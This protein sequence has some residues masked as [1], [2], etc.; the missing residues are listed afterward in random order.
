MR[1]AWPTDSAR[2]ASDKGPDAMMFRKAAGIVAHM[3]LMAVILVLPACDQIGNPL[4]AIGARIPPP[5]EFQV[6]ARK[7][8]MM[9]AGQALPEPRPGA[10]SPLD[11]DP[12]GD[13][14][15]AL[16]GT[17]GS[18]LL[19]S[20]VPSAGELILLSSANAAVAAGDIRARLEADRV[21]EA[22]NKPFEP[23][24]VRE[25]LGIGDA[26]NL[27]EATLVDPIAEYLRL[28]REGQLTPADPAAVAATG[29]AA[30]VE[31]VLPPYPIGRHQNPIKPEG[32]GPAL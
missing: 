12:H 28:Q 2:R 27:D 4:E 31:S 23:P 25:L 7:P 30:P 22:A 17:S 19:S 1:A 6:I 14:A 24:S 10:P 16:L 8:L 20:A 13:A 3:G 29:E 21:Q 5:D 11:P 9:P 32:T 26:E 15:R 18:A